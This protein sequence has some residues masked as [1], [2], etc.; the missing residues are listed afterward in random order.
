MNRSGL[1]FL[2]CLAAILFFLAL[3]A[4][5][6]GWASSTID[7]QELEQMEVLLNLDFD[8]LASIKITTV[9]RKKQN[10]ADIAAAVYVISQEDIRRSGLGSVPEL[11]RMVP[12]LE[13]ASTGSNSWS[14]TSRGFNDR[15]SNKL[16]VL[17]DGRSVFT[18]LFAGVYWEMQDLILEDI[19]R[20]EIIRGPGGA[21]WG[22]NAVNGVIN[23]ITKHAEDTQGGQFTLSSGNQEPYSGTIRYGGKMGE[24]FSYRVFA[25]GFDR[26]SFINSDGSRAEDSWQ[27]KQGGFR[28]DW[29]LTKDNSL[30]VQGNTNNVDTENDTDQNTSNNVLLRW[31]HDLSDASD[32][33]IQL[34]YD[35]FEHDRDIRKTYDLDFQHRFPLYTNQ[36]I[37]WGLGYRTIE[38]SIE[39]DERV[40][41]NP[42]SRHDEIFSAFIQDEIAFL[43]DSLKFTIGSKFEHNDYTGLEIQPNARLLWKAN[44][45]D[46]YWAAISRAVRTPSR[47]ES[48]ITAT[49][50]VTPLIGNPDMQSETLLAYEVGYRS[51]ISSRLSFDITSYYNN[52]DNLQTIESNAGSDVFANLMEGNSYGVESAVEWQP[53]KVWKLKANYTFIKMNLNLKDGSSSTSSTNQENNTP[54]HQFQIHSYLDL[55]NNLEFDA[56]LYYSNEISAMG[57]PAYFRTDLR[58][59]WRPQKQLELS[60]VGQNL[61]DTQHP[62]SSALKNATNSPSITEVPRSVLVKL[63]WGF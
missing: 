36:E 17:I 53:K 45:R 40:S 57:I 56:A 18:P 47:Y 41:F 63:V 39:I 48:D 43:E 38:D 52:Y 31:E 8:G 46:T 49:R 27:S 55:P 19:D 15:F 35:A 11:L 29:L 12:G 3:S 50:S 51:Q 16:L 13:V 62:E 37:I 24:K 61:F 32:L 60:L 1:Y 5:S 34:Y 22:A 9:N 30:T 7:Q 20:I 58:L 14:I 42:Q 26:D 10:V 59:G 44:K 6:P 54:T 21:L 2:H 23:I 25:K 4:P 28:M 33:A